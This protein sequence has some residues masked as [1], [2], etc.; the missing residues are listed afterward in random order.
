MVAQAR[1]AEF[2]ALRPEANYQLKVADNLAWVSTAK[3][4]FADEQVPQQQQFILGGMDTL[5]AYLPGILVGDE[6][7]FADTRLES[8]YTWND[9]IVVPSVFVE[10]GGAWYNNA[11]SPQG[12]EQTIGDAGLRLKVNY[13]SFLY[14]EIVAARPVYDDVA[15]DDRLDDLEAD[16]YWRIRATF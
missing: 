1:T 13:K 7:Y 11:G 15:D 8:R 3:A 16:F 2:I 4:Q 10:Y 6:G 14:T 5:S 9:F 12:D